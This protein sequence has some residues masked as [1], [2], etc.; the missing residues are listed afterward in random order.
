MLTN[1]KW[2]KPYILKF[3]NIFSHVKQYLNDPEK[4]LLQNIGYI[5]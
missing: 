1:I 4:S 2:Y 3:I 5:S